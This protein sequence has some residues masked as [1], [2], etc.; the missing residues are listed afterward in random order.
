M[1]LVIFSVLFPLVN[2]VHA[3]SVERLGRSEQPKL[4][5]QGVNYLGGDLS[6]IKKIP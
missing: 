3:D 6:A 2:F 1:G 4:L 5:S